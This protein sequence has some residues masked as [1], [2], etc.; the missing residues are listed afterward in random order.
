[1]ELVRVVS[2][3]D[4][5]V[6]ILDSPGLQDSPAGSGLVCLVMTLVSQDSRDFLDMV[7][8]DRQ[9]SLDMDLP[10]FLDIPPMDFPDR[11]DFLG[12]LPVRQDTLL[13]DSLEVPDRLD[14]R[15]MDTERQFHP[16]RSPS[17]INETFSVH[18]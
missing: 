10:D 9:D 14:I 6:V 11:Q 15:L 2:Q 3:E 18:E 12:T 8:M 4:W 5:E 13:T 16:R 1:M 17:I 7:L